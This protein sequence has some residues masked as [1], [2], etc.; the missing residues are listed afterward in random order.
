MVQKFLRRLSP[1]VAFAIAA[2]LLYSLTIPISKMFLR[3]VE[4]WM[5]AGLLDLGAGIGM[6]IVYFLRQII[7]R[8]PTLNRLRRQD[9]SWLLASIFAGSL[10]AS[11]LQVYGI[12][13]STAASAALLL[14]LE[15]VFT[16]LVAWLIF[17]EAFNRQ[18]AIGLAA[19]TAGSIILAWTGESDLRFSWGSLA[20]VGSCIGWATSSNLTYKISS[21]DAVQVAMVKNLVSGGFNVSLALA[22][23]NSL[24]SAGMGAKIA[25]A[26]FITIGLT[27]VCFILALRHLTPSKVGTF[28]SI[29]PFAGAVL[30]VVWLGEPVTS[31]L[32]AAAGLMAIGLWFCL[33]RKRSNAPAG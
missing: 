3:Q 23:G 7:T 15:G 25:I 33:H 12:A 1:G 11:V 26:G 21:R 28:F 17:R 22:V 30:A 32:V 5:L 9:W 18:V 27:Y 20:V 19:I 2:P 6:A 24:P 8:K 16:A 13:H 10:M 31:Q 14:N 4:P 29:F